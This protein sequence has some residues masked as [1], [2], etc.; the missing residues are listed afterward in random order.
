MNSV[1]DRRPLRQPFVMPS[2]LL[3][4]LSHFRNWVCQH[5]H[6]FILPCSW[7]VGILPT[8]ATRAQEKYAGG[9]WER[10]SHLI[11]REMHSKQNPLS[12]SCFCKVLCEVMMFRA[13]AV[14]EDNRGRKGGKSQ[15]SWY[16]WVTE[17]TLEK[18]PQDFLLWKKLNPYDLNHL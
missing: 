8:L 13:M 6:F 16:F 7:G 15:E 17:P 18:V 2:S 14:I 9:S 12:L 11:K 3:V 1:W 10:F 4:V 5:P